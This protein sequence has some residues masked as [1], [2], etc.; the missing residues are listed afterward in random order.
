M[1]A[2]LRR[3]AGAQP[4]VTFA[5]R[6]PTSDCW[7]LLSETA[8]ATLLRHPPAGVAQLD[9]ETP[10]AVEGPLRPA[11]E[12]AT[13]EAGAFPRAYDLMTPVFDAA[14]PRRRAE[15]AELIGWAPAFEQVAARI[16]TRTVAL[17]D[18]L[19]PAVLESLGAP[20]AETEL[21]VRE[22]AGLLNAIADLQILVA[23][24]GGRPWLDGMAK[25]FPWARWTPSWSLVR[26]RLIGFTPAAAWSVQAIGPGILG[27]YLDAL[28]RA[29]HLMLIFDAL[30]GLAALGISSPGDAPAIIAEIKSRRA[31]VRTPAPEEQ[32]LVDWLV[33]TAC[34]VIAAPE[35]TKR[36]LA[37]ATRF[38]GPLEA[39]RLLLHVLANT[40]E[41]DAVEPLIGQRAPL[42]FALLPVILSGRRWDAYPEDPTRSDMPAQIMADALRRA[43]GGAPRP[44]ALVH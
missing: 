34:E 4:G 38:D 30:F 42:A 5:G 21:R 32:A 26:E 36:Q 9:L 41:H 23:D 18:G 27:A 8:P 31:F 40:R 28:V 13:D 25:S 35:Q 19:R 6:L 39:G 2:D 17:V 11:L 24:D 22:Y 43:W 37:D 14:T 15:M 12:K 7:I 33:S 10:L 44:K 1:Q 16:S 3:W 20:N 29:D